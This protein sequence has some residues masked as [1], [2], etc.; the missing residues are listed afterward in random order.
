MESRVKPC[1][2]W[3]L[4]FKINTKS[5]STFGF[6]LLEAAF[7]VK[8]DFL[9][10][11]RAAWEGVSSLHVGW[12]LGQRTRTLHFSGQVMLRVRI[13]IWTP[14]S[15]PS[16]QS[17][18]EMVFVERL[19]TWESMLLKW[20]NAGILLAVLTGTRLYLIE[21]AEFWSVFALFSFDCFLLLLLLFLNA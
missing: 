13:S 21:S 1:K 7:R 4:E 3:Y 11:P 20:E 14:T 19:E 2:L 16:D 10:S 12:C 17:C 6:W 15:F 5:F 9:A 8:D 18:T